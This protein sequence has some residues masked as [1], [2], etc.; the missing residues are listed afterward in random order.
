MATGRISVVGLGPAG[1]EFLTAETVELLRSGAPVW[2]RT[3]R[4]P[5]ADGL[6]V[7]GSFDD[8]YETLGSFEEVYATIVDRLIEFA[9]SAGHVVYA[10]PGSPVV[11]ERTVEMIRAHRRVVAGD[12]ELAVRPALAF[13]E[14]CWNAL[15]I[16]PMAVGAT[17]IDAY[18]LTVQ[19]AGRLGPLLITQ[20]HS[21]EVL[22][23]VIDALADV[24]PK[25]VT[26]LQRIGSP[27]ELVREVDWGDLR[28]SVT[29][30]HLTSL[31]VPRFETPLAATL[32]SLEES[33]RHVLERSPG[34]AQ[35]S[36][37]AA[38]SKLPETVAAVVTEADD[39][40]TPDVEEPLSDML[41]IVMLIARLSARAGLFSLEDLAETA[42]E[43]NSD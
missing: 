39:S 7:E 3:S 19:G 10:V 1:A 18:G 36:L 20:V 17:I 6:I 22:S 24:A 34:D 21:A 42:V 38:I 41:F 25:S 28:N 43:R 23:D 15:E 8:L 9:Q 40:Q 11:A 26:V 13:T 33:L 29:P 14:L 27:H 35:T 30:D 31:W 32:V 5:A 12:I 4:H 2:L 37:A 16:D